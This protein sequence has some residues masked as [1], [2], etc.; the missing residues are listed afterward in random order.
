MPLGLGSLVPIGGQV[1]ALLGTNSGHIGSE[2]LCHSE[3]IPF[4]LLGVG[5]SLRFGFLTL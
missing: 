4:K 1:F 3:K 5:V 2:S